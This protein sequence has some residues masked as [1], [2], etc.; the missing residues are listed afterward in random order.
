MRAYSLILRMEPLSFQ[1]FD[2]YFALIFTFFV[3]LWV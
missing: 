1:G 3:P 2:L